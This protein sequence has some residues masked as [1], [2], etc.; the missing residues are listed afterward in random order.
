MSLGRL[1]F[2]VVVLA[3]ASQAAAGV[4]SARACAP[5]DSVVHTF[6]GFPDNDPPGPATAYDCGRNFEAG[7]IGTF[8]DP[9]TMASAEGEFD[10]C[11]IIYV[12]Y[13]KKYARYEDFCQQCTDDWASGINHIDLWTGS[14][15][16][17]GGDSQIDCEN[18]LTPDSSPQI[19]RNPATDL[20][21]D[22]TVLYD[23]VSDTCEI[24]HVYPT[25]N[26]GDF[27]SA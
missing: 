12:P 16:Q 18:N 4:L 26:V 25:F 22:T 9:L 19:I 1:E 2:T 8:D 11:E 15:N 24:A 17:S 23:P 20:D 27:C 7:G 6:Y 13:L 10:E 21:V 14:P 3:F 5:V